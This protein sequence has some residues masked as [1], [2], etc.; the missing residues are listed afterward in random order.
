MAQ[1]SVRGYALFAGLDDRAFDHVLQMGREVAFEPGKAIF[2]AGDQ[3]DDVFVILEGEARVDVG[4][5]FHRLTP[6]DFFGEMALLAPDRR[7]ATVRA[8]NPLRV[9]QIPAGAF[10]TLI[11]EHPQLGLS[12]ISMLV[13][14]LREVEQR[15]DAWIAS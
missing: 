12:V 10:T 3:G 1:A 6:G 2:E 15:I 8:V 13:R 5:R 7:M 14:R 9:L 4:G 11:L